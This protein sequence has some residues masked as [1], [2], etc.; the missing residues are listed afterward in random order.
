LSQHERHAQ[1]AALLRHEGTVRIA[2]L[3]KA[4][5]VTT[6]TVRRDLDELA[7]SGVLKRTYGGGAS[8]SLTD[9]PGI[10]VRSRKHAAERGLI[11]RAAARMVED[12]DALMVDCGS[13]TRLFAQM[14]AARELRLT[15]VTNCLPVAKALGADPQCR[16]ILCCGDY[17][18]GE[19]GVYGAVAGDFIRRFKANKAF[20]GAGGVT[21]EGVT[22]ADSLGCSIKRAM[23]DSAEQTV[24]LVDSSKY[25]VVQFERVCALTEIDA[26]VSEARPPKPLAASL[27]SAG[28]QV[29]VAA[30]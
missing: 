30:E 9:E 6:E 21:R 8:R 29:V 17:V 18:A 15:V 27:K 16:T 25:D 22:D 26:L 19:D 4:F 3:A 2:T 24:L 13:T 23:M 11:A 5:D 7:E 10:G 20:I 1:I 14:L 12:G 28:V